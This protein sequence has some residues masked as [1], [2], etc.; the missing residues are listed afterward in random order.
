[1]GRRD[2]EIWHKNLYKERQRDHRNHERE[3]IGKKNKA[4]SSVKIF[5]EHVIRLKSDTVIADKDSHG[6]RNL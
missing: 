6:K 1:M 4:D 3:N 2:K 5:G